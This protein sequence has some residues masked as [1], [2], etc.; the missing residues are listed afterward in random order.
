[1]LKDLLIYGSRHVWRNLEENDFLSF[2][3][4]IC[5]YYNNMNIQAVFLIVL[6]IILSFA[7]FK[8]FHV[9]AGNFKRSSTLDAN[10]GKNGFWFLANDISK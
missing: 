8:I 6:T 4:L 5:L 9:A 1:M 10:A 2:L 7:I 3:K